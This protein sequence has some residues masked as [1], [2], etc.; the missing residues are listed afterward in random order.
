MHA[1]W[2]LL[3]PTLRE[4][5]LAWL[6][7][8]RGEEG[9][10]AG[11]RGPADPYYTDFGMRLLDLSD[12]PPG[13]FRHVASYLQSLPPAADVVD[14]FSRSNAARLLRSRGIPVADPDNVAAVLAIQ[15]AHDGGFTHPGGTTTSA[16]MT[17]L[18]TLI[19]EMR[20]EPFAEA[21]KA[22]AALHRLRRPNGGFADQAGHESAQTSTTAAALVSLGKLGGLERSVAAGAAQF[23]IRLQDE[24]GGLRAH[25]DAPEAD[26]LS[27]FTAIAAL[28]H[29]DGLRGLR[30]AAAARFVVNRRMAGGFSAS[31]TDAEADVEYT[32][33]GIG[34]LCLLRRHLESAC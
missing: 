23:L 1:G 24:S 14:L 25:E 17:F 22:V 7:G 6:T 9:G 31:E 12:G 4:S 28:S 19:L 16:Y 11:R 3:A 33:Y 18:A 29:L 20:D 13:D 30:L 8:F 27:T 5:V 26:L 2:A 15:R 32:Y 34:C 10:Y 21:R